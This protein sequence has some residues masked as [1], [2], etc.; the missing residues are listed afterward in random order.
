MKTNE[1]IRFIRFDAEIIKTQ[2][3]NIEVIVY[4]DFYPGFD[5]VSK[6][7]L[8]EETISKVETLLKITNIKKGN[9]TY[10]NINKTVSYNLPKG[11]RLKKKLKEPKKCFFEK[12]KDLFK[13]Q[14]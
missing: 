2:I 4:T 12:I 11:V 14:I 9:F 8:S 5:L 1:N 3:D 6:D 10:D 7:D 13:T